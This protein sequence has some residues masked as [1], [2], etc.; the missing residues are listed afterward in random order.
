MTKESTTGLMRETAESSGS[1]A[2]SNGSAPS[3]T[4]YWVAA[5]VAIVAVGCGVTWGVLGTM[6]ARDHAQSLPRANAPGRL[7]VSAGAGTSKLIYFEGEG[8]PSP[9]A[10]GLSVL[11]PD[12]SSVRVEPYD[13][14]MKYDIAG[15]VG[16]PIASFSAQTAGTYTVV[17]QSAFHEGRISA[18]DNFVR[19]Q[20]INVVGALALIAV[21]GVTGL[22][23]V[24][25]KR[26][27]AA[28]RSVSRSRLRRR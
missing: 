22:A 3:K 2:T 9:D 16:T 28:G 27:R 7:E 5:V 10:L 15:W 19:T 11:A 13:V 25:M 21:G 26:S 8:R 18:G 23:V 14:V 1:F 17:A 12:G 20:A 4:W 6:R 24:A